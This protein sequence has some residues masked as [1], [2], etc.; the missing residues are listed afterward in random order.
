[1]NWAATAHGYGIAQFGRGGP[2]WLAHRISWTLH[3]GRIPV[4]LMVLHHCDTPA[5]INPDHLFLG[6]ALANVRD[7]DRKGRGRRLGVVG[8]RQP[9]AKLTEADI[10]AIRSDPRTHCQIAA[11][12]GVDSSLIS[13]IKTRRR[14]RHV[15]SF[16]SGGSAP[17]RRERRDPLWR[18]ALAFLLCIR[19]AG[20]S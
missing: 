9:T 18:D 8:S 3:R 16:G 15:S 20:G 10:P 19:G 17:D 11:E 12:Y 2:V 14:W 1:M 5:C 13:R 7:M 4:G 6:D